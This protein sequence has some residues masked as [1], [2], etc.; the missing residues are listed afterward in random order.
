MIEK[1]KKS[2]A[3]K[4]MQDTQDKHFGEKVR[5]R[6]CEV[7]C[8]TPAITFEYILKRSLNCDP[9]FLLDVLHELQDDDFI[10]STEDRE[11]PAR[12]SLKERDHYPH[13]KATRFRRS[14]TKPSL[15]ISLDS[16]QTEYLRELLQEM[17]DSFPEEAP[18][19]SQWWF[20]ESIYEN[21]IKLVLHLSKPHAPLAFLG[22]GTLGALLSHFSTNPVNIF[23]VDGILLERISR[24]C[25]KSTQTIR[26]DVSNEPDSSFKEK[27]QLV[28]VDPPWSSSMLQTF[29]VRSSTF[30]CTG[31][32]LAISFPP[33]LT[34][35]SIEEERK[36]LLKLAKSLGLSLKLTLP[37][38]T[39]YSVPAFERNAYE[40][41]GIH[42]QKPWRRGDL[43]V[44]TKTHHSSP[45]IM[46]LI[47]KMSEWSQYNLRKCRLFIKR[48]GLFEDGP[49]SVQPIPGVDDLMHKSASTR[50]ASWKSA[51]LV[52]TH[53]HIAHAYG[54]KELS[55]L[56]ERT[57]GQ[58]HGN[59]ENDAGFD[60][61]IPAEIKETISSMLDIANSQRGKVSK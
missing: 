55:T 50:M 14:A 51:S 48:D 4:L 60:A 59:Y 44:F 26:Y 29:L 35:P 39:E 32:S 6:V 13:P 23:D 53:N 5:V 54:R 33:I 8:A 1:T 25:S 12:Y 42:L 31:G 17:L 18:V 46:H 41:C 7:L 61:M 47:E 9:S 43:F 40:H 2:A 57:F 24:Y 15:G 49:P 36:E 56:L 52:S 45:D 20:S 34:R 28:F 22:S 11:S 16:P 21:L 19:Y 3:R 27:F 10:S 37:S 38:F 58:D 30:V